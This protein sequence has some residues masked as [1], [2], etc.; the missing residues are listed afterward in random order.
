[1]NRASSVV[2]AIALAL[3]AA[4]A[5]ARGLEPLLK[6]KYAFTGEATCLLSDGGFNPDGTPVGPPAPFPSIV[7]FS[8]HGV[9]TFNGD[10]TGTLEARV[11]AISHPFALPP[12]PPARPA[13]LF[14]RGAVSSMEISASFT[15]SVSHDLTFEMATPLVTGNVLTGPRAGQTME[16]TGLPLFHG[17]ISEDLDSLTLAHEEPAV[18]TQTFSNGDFDYRMC[19]RSR[20]LHERRGHRHGG[21]R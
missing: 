10:G 21:R 8:V 4:S 16:I 12:S 14:V 19:H 11:I 15:Y 13:P 17:F 2:L 5:Q 20:V 3:G 7:S 1:M 6:G 9:R 18:E